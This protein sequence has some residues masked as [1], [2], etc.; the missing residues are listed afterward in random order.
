MKNKIL[1]DW[2]TQISYAYAIGTILIVIL[3]LIFNGYDKIHIFIEYNPLIR[4]LEVFGGI[5][6]VTILFINF[7]RRWEEM[8]K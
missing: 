6:S 8:C 1:W 3:S 7:F 5:F 4:F 2:L